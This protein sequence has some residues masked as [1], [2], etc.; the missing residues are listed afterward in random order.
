MMSSRRS[1]IRDSV[2]AGTIAAVKPLACQP[3]AAAFLASALKP[4]DGVIRLNSNENAYGPSNKVIAAI[5]AAL[6][7]SNRYPSMEYPNLIEQ[8]ASF[9]RVKPEQVLLGCGSTEILR[10]AACAFLGSGKQLIHA[11]PT[12]GAIVTYADAV[13]SEGIPVPLTRGL[14]HDLDGM[15]HRVNASTTLVYVCNPN[16]PTASLTPRHDLETFITKLP[17]SAFVLIDEAYHHYVGTSGYASFIDRPT[18]DGRVIVCRTF[19]A[20]YG[21]A[22]LRVG[23]AIS[24]P[25]VIQQM[26][27]FLTE[28]NIN[29]IARQAVSAAL[30]DSDGLH[31][32]ME[33]NAND[34]QEFFNS[35]MARGQKGIDSHANF[36]FINSF[37][38]ADRVIEHFR[39]HN[40]LIGPRFREMD[41]FIRISL[42]RPEEMRQFWHAWDM[43]PGIKGKM[44]H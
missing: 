14:A 18:E 24:S 39:S 32:A 21:L 3:A 13:G 28:D 31:E 8:I 41:T 7:R 6:S 1:F 16:N 2:S 33:R 42:G 10:V 26:R 15:L 9:H 11:S 22:G 17:A 43:L 37:S 20:I 4:D 19:S 5:S 36:V 12:Y 38:P 34:R 27:R 35:A 40:I 44:A 25:K 29:S 23:Y 30:E